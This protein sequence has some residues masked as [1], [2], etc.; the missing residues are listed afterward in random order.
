MPQTEQSTFYEKFLYVFML[1]SYLSVLF[2]YFCLSCECISYHSYVLTV[3]RA[4]FS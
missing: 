4:E 2:I 3:S 1:Y